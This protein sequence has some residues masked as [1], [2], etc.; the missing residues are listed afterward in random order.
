ML[1]QKMASLQPL[2]FN[3]VTLNFLTSRQGIMLIGQ[4]T[5]RGMVAEQVYRSLLND[6]DLAIINALGKFNVKFCLFAQR[7]FIYL[8]FQ[9]GAAG[10]G[11]HGAGAPQM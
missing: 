7:S 1:A 10:D 8:H 6:E 3:F 4:R 5:G 2:R 11:Q 9:V